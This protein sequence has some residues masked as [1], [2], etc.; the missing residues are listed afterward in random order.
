MKK[1]DTFLPEIQTIND[2]KNF[3]LLK[4]TERRGGIITSLSFLF[5]LFFSISFLLPSGVVAQNIQFTGIPI[6]PAV[7]DLGCLP[8]APD[9]LSLGVSATTDCS[10][11]IV[12]CEAGA[13]ASSTCQFTQSFVYSAIDECLNPISGT[14]TYT[15]REDTEAPVLAGIP[16]ATVD[17]GCTTDRPDCGTATVTATDNCDPVVTVTCEA[18]AIASSTCQFTQSFVY[19]AIDECLNPISGTITYTWR[20]DTEAPVLAGIPTATVDLGCTTD[21]PD[22]GTATVTATDNCDPVVTVTCEAGAIASS[23]C[24]FTQS[25]VYSAIDEC[26]NP[27]SG[28]ITYTWRE[29][30]EAPVI[31]TTA[32]SGPIPG[33]CCNPDVITPTFTGLDNCDGVF[34]PT[35]TTAGPINTGGCE[36]EQTWEANHTDACGNAATPVSITYTWIGDLVGPTLHWMIP[37]LPT[38]IEV[39]WPAGTVELGCNPDVLPA[40]NELVTASDNCVGSTAVD[41]TAGPISG[42]CQKTQIFTY[43]AEDLCCNVTTKTVTYT[44][45]DDLVPPY[46]TG[47][48]DDTDLDCNPTDMPDCAEWDVKAYD[49]CDGE[50]SPCLVTCEAGVATKTSE[51]DWTQTF[52]FT[53]NDACDNVG[54][55]SA[56]FIWRV[57]LTPPVLAGLPEDTDLGK[58]PDELPVC[59]DFV[60]VTATDVCGIATVTCDASVVTATDNCGMVGT[61]TFSFSAY[62]ECNN[63]ATPVGV[64]FTWIE[65]WTPPQFVGIPTA[66]VDLACNPEPPDENTTVVTATDNCDGV[67]DWSCVPGPETFTGCQY[68]QTFVYTAVDACEN[69][70]SATITYTWKEDLVA[71][72]LAGVPDGG[73]LGCNPEVPTCGTFTVTAEDN[74]DL[75]VTVTCTD[76]GD[77]PT[78]PNCHWTKTLT[79]YAEDACGNGVTETATFTW[80][81]DKAKPIITI[82][83]Y[84]ANLGCNPEQRGVP[85]PACDPL[86]SAYD[87]CD[88]PLTPHCEVLDPEYDG[89]L[90]TQKVVYTATDICCNVGVATATYFWKEDLIPPV[91]GNVPDDEDLGCNP[92]S[93]PD[94]DDLME[95]ITA[96]DNCDDDLED[97]CMDCTG[98]PIT[99]TNC[100]WTV[101][102]QFRAWDLCGNIGTESVTYTWRIDTD[103]PV[104]AGIPDTQPIDLGYCPDL[105]TCGTTTV[106][107]S[108]LCGEVVTFTCE[109]GD[110]VTTTCNWEQ[111]FTYTAVD[112]CKNTAVASI[113]Y[114]WV[115]DHTAPELFGI[116]TATAYLGCNPDALPGCASATVY[117]ED[118]CDGVVTV[119]C[120]PGEI[121]G[122]CVKEQIFTYTAKDKCGNEAS[123]TAAYTWKVDTEGPVFAGLPVPPTELICDLD[124]ECDDFNVT[125]TDYCD[126]PVSVTCSAGAITGECVVSQPFYFY[127]TD[128]CGNGVTETVTFTWREDHVRP[129]ISGVPTSDII[130][131]CN[132]DEYLPITCTNHPFIGLVTA[133]D[134][135]DDIVGVSCQV[136]TATETG[137]CEWM[138]TITFFATDCCLNT[139]SQTATYRWK[140]DTEPPQ[141]IGLPESDDLGCN[142]VE[143]G[144]PIPTCSDFDVTAVDNCGDCACVVVCDEGEIVSDGCDKSLTFTFTVED[145]C[146]NV[147]T[148]YVTYTWREDLA[149]PVL[150]GVP[151]GADL[152]LCP[153]E[154]PDCDDFSVNADDACDGVWSATCTSELIG[155]DA[156]SYSKIFTFTAVD[157]CGNGVTE[158]VTYTWLGSGEPPVISGVPDDEYLGC[159]PLDLPSCDGF[160][161]ISATDADSNPVSVSCTAD[162]PIE[163]DCLRSQTFWFTASDVCNQTGTESVTYTWKEDL[164]APEWITEPEDRFLGCNVATPTCDDFEFTAMDNCDGVITTLC[165]I[166]TAEGECD[167]SMECT[168]TA[169]DLCGNEISKTI[170]YTW[171]IDHEAPVLSNL[172]TG[173]NLGC[174]PPS[175]PECNDFNVIATDNCDGSDIVYC[176]QIGP[177]GDCFM[178]LVF[179]F[180]ATDLCGNEVSETV[181]YTYK[182]DLTPPVLYNVPVGGILGCPPELPTCAPLNIPD[183]VYAVDVCD[184]AICEV[185]CIPGDLLEYGCTT[186]Q[187]FTYKAVDACGNWAIEEVTYTWMGEQGNPVISTEAFDHDLGCNPDEVEAPV[188]TGNDGCGGA[189]EPIVTT[190]GPM[191]VTG[192]D[193]TQTWTAN[194]T[195]AC[196]NVA[197]RMWRVQVRP[198]QAAPTPKRGRPTIRMPAAMWP[199]RLRSPTPGR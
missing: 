158:T 144:T 32:V 3:T 187:T 47:V 199:H 115:E 191:V 7:V 52:L 142:P 50:V 175:L 151:V 43:T 2:M 70:A 51:C 78:T 167:K 85:M 116:P 4:K 188:F 62:D 193:Y 141:F 96:E 184:G 186:S 127:A 25:F 179:V 110:I 180:T 165:S 8:Q 5:V 57:D 185:E 137:D 99:T 135:C 86:A 68:T 22:C 113:T 15:W 82:P 140:I 16:T 39:S 112:E 28:T 125:A 139:A 58:C 122:D 160:T 173:G 153:D 75:A 64:V 118:I 1:T 138:Q 56:T 103:P 182:F 183:G 120:D 190:T 84:T 166:G 104:I 49:E 196:G 100:D 157:F 98:V 146:L 20:E 109:A 129:V 169:V 59:E 194:Y 147:N 114:V 123:G 10:G 111:V 30:T 63:V 148:A 195:D 168:Y 197:T 102:Y 150:M 44:W 61:L 81:A 164:V 13:I 33:D 71:P 93:I 155:P 73:Y 143:N 53:A 171:K 162:D 21:R 6:P 172:P 45:K 154:V 66:T 17:L 124:P 79:W 83:P 108:D 60:G 48:P 174:N 101:T 90:V 156:G 74:C 121:T 132:P 18:G 31:S 198:I 42:T 107:A 145:A 117:A 95:I 41:C 24:Q 134:N 29:D 80:K 91:I 163:D 119:T 76:S 27:V 159:N 40:C 178:T 38:P 19:S 12:T 149:A 126:G 161:G 88:G 152:G 26:L 14:I 11:G 189:F 46:F 54:T 181:T 34:T 77:E 128:Q 87:D 67:V 192:C 35:V 55:E 97:C 106:T 136:G 72:D 105:P 69:T 131:G 37:S 92:V 65:D 89:C 9:C 177:E 133:L 94:C 176:D 23:T 130:L 170:T 36:W